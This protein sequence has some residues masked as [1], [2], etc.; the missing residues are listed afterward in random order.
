MSAPTP[1]LAALARAAYQARRATD[2]ARD[3]ERDWY[4]RRDEEEHRHAAAGRTLLGAAQE[5]PNAR[6]LA[7]HVA[8]RERE[9]TAAEQAA[10]G[11][12]YRVPVDNLAALRTAVERLTRRAAKLDLD[13]IT[14]TDADTEIVE[15]EEH[16]VR[17]GQEYRYVVLAGPRPQLAG[18]AFIAVL[19][20]DH[21]GD[22][23]RAI[24]RRVPQGTWGETPDADLAAYRTAQ[25]RCEHCD[26]LRRRNDTY[27]V[28]SEAGEIKQVGSSCLRDFTG[29]P[30]PDAIARL[31][32]SFADLAE[33]AEDAE[34]D[35]PGV[36]GGLVLYPV[37]AYLT[38]VAQE[39]RL[40]GW[41]PRSRAAGY[42][43]ATADRA[44]QAIRAATRGAKIALPEPAD[45]ET[46]RNALAWVRDTLA[47]KS[48]LSDFEH[49]LIVAVDGDHLVERRAGIAAAAINAYRRERERQAAAEQDAGHLGAIKQ[50]LDVT[51][52][53]VS[54]RYRET[55]YGTTS[56][57]KLLDEAGHRLVWF[58]SNNVLREGATYTLRG[59]V[60][61]HGDWQGQSETH[62][63]R[64]KVLAQPE[65]ETPLHT[66]PDAELDAL[67]RDHHDHRVCDAAADELAAR[68]HDRHDPSSALGVHA[69]S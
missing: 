33:D 58:A 24:I 28:Q 50:R 18:W 42:G 46:A 57:Y 32:E 25:A 10:G 49:N 67:T 59:T 12:V 44:L 16:G 31:A 54:V 17:V 48:D 47:H 34:R 2:Q 41:T 21:E 52:T 64:C 45:D 3:E 36:G 9:Q 53:V 23:P 65:P 20:H 6:R 35:E 68:E 30:S 1:D 66:L 43:D 38:F 55:D 11:R 14:L 4:E 51:V 5:H 27:L 63:T 26:T 19:E 39:I 69:P 37:D 40:N 13:P 15:R 7:G 62:L 29:H 60:N 56:I 8:D 22:Q 61:A